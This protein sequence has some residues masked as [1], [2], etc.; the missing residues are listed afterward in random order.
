MT[1]Q[2]HFWIC[3]HKTEGRDSNRVFYTHRNSSMACES[4]WRTAQTRKLRSLC[5]PW[6]HWENTKTKG[7]KQSVCPS[8]DE[9][10]INKLWS[11]HKMDYYSALKT[12]KNSNMCYNM[13]ALSGHHAEWNT[14][15]TGRQTRC[16]YI[17]VQ[18]PEQS[19]SHD[20]GCRGWGEGGT[21]NYLTG[22]VAIGVDGF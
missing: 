5:S 13:T 19:H 18:Y 9:K 17:Y 21:G 22:T 8:R 11:V 2:F 3:T 10:W 1:Q 4:C 16:G 14:P 15:A 7:R 12:K 20:A 6:K